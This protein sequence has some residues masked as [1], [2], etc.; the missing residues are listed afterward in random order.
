M[1]A[2]G[3]GSVSAPRYEAAGEVDSVEPEVEDGGAVESDP[4]IPTDTQDDV[5]LSGD[6]GEAG[7]SESPLLGGLSSNFSAAP[8]SSIP[9]PTAGQPDEAAPEKP[10][11]QNPA[12]PDPHFKYDGVPWK[13]HSESIGWTPGSKRESP[14]QANEAI[15]AGY[16][17]LNKGMQDYLKG[18][19]NG[20]KLPELA[21]WSTFGKYASPLAGEQIRNLQD[22][23]L[24]K[25][26]DLE[27]ARRLQK[28]ATNLETINQG[29]A[30]TTD[31]L[32]GNAANVK[33]LDAA[34][35]PLGETGKVLGETAGDLAFTTPSTMLDA[36]VRGNNGIY[37][38]FAPAYDAFLKGEADGTG[39]M[40]A[41]KAAGYE[42][43][44]DKDRQ[45][46]ISDSLG[47][48]KEARD[49]GLQA[50]KETDPARR[51][52]LLKQ[53]QSL[54][55]TANL[56]LGNQEQIEVIQQPGVFGHPEVAKRIGALGGTMSMHDANG[57]TPLL[58]NGGNWSDFATRMG[59]KEV[60]EGTEGAMKIRH[61][62]GKVHN[63][64]VDPT[65][66][67][68]IS[69]YFTQNLS[70]PRA[71]KLNNSNPQSLYR[72]TTSNSGSQADGLARD[73]N[74]GNYTDA[75]GK[76]ASLPVIAGGDLTAYGG[77]KLSQAGDR[78][79][80]TGAVRMAQAWQK[81]ETLNMVRGGAELGLGAVA[82]GGGRVMRSAGEN[83][84]FGGQV[85]G[86]MWD[87]LRGK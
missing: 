12:Q 13:D 50:Q 55:E 65:Q 2:I 30:L 59:Y 82:S 35:N 61:P 70:G 63:Y 64:Q 45:G 62:D 34:L 42:P 24:A 28:N 10:A 18:D 53:R 49:L 78:K 11:D 74:R 47:K 57:T 38:N 67:G 76:A 80:V 22:V 75:V 17:D 68:T 86:T 23:E 87:M 14:T 51:D 84:S 79:A 6:A 4:E 81:G 21:D 37:N 66:K 85:M 25:S 60:P 52:E 39:G 16:M 32:S 20:P 43:G 36:L 58:P 33:P 1:D 41:L 83:I 71:A 72:P 56:N 44:S 48:Y 15:T 19:P 54:V 46:F 5:S 40:E 26:G 29:L 9:E 7:E 31:S 27:A 73:L 3:G 69:E 77:D 8:N